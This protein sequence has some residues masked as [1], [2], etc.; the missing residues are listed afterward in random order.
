M[1]K[2]FLMGLVPLVVVA[3]FL[4][5]PAA[6]QGVCGTAPKCPHVYKNGVIAKEG[7]KVRLLNWGVLNL[8]TRFPAE[9]HYA[10][11]GFLENPP[12]AG[13]QATGLVQVFS[14]YEC[15]S[16]E[17]ILIG[18][19]FFELKSEQLP[20]NVE[21]TEPSAGVFRQKTG[22]KGEKGGKGSQE[23]FWS[24]EG[25]AG[26]HIFGETS[27]LI[28]NNGTAIGLKPGEIEFEAG[29]GELE[30]ESPGP[31]FQKNFKQQGFAG[32]ELIEVRNP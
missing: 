12:G 7:T 31:K 29:S 27:P 18:G 20:W 13:Q 14:P 3:A 28:L 6:S 23:L 4:V 25:I 32:Q 1:K 15:V 30:G 8:T 24:C 9:C 22:V 16:T 17:C 19:K 26:A 5:I 10:V 2:K 11:A 21:I